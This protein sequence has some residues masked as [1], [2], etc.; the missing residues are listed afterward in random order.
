MAFYQSR[1][2]RHRPFNQAN[3]GMSNRAIAKEAGV[4]APTVAKARRATVNGF[5]VDEPRTGLD[6]RTRKMPTRADMD[7]VTTAAEE[8]MRKWNE[9]EADPNSQT[10]V[11]Q[12]RVEMR[13]DPEA[14]E[15]LLAELQ[16]LI[17][18]G[19]DPADREQFALR[20]RLAEKLAF[21]SGPVVV[22]QM[23]HLSSRS[24]SACA[25]SRSMTVPAGCRPDRPWSRLPCRPTDTPTGCSRTQARA[26][27]HVG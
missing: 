20:A 11:R 25:A 1:S 9:E 7:A 24:F 6:G 8:D 5:T 27:R 3:P 13:A 19:I 12:T 22:R 15:V 21:Y 10:W 23:A 14:I 2:N 17:N 18:S 4:S 26:R 16:A